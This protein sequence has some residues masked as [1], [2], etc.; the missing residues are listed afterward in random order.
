MSGVKIKNPATALVVSVRRVNVTDANARQIHVSVMAETTPATENSRTLPI[1]PARST[2][3]VHTYKA[4]RTTGVIRMSLVF[5]I[6]PPAKKVSSLFGGY[7]LAKRQ[8]VGK[9]RKYVRE[10]ITSAKGNSDCQGLSGLATFRAIQEP[11][12]NCYGAER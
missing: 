7:W 5:S 1:P 9:G 11:S 12:P 2:A 8:S 3:R 6:A 10:K 4:R